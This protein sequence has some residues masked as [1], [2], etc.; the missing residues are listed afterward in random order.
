MQFAAAH[1]AP[2]DVGRLYNA[3]YSIMDNADNPAIG[4]LNNTHV[5]HLAF[6]LLSVGCRVSVAASDIGPKVLNIM[7]SA[8]E[9]R[10]ACSALRRVVELSF[11][12]SISLP[13]QGG[14]T[15]WLNR[16]LNQKA[17]KAGCLTQKIGKAGCL[18]QKLGKAGCPNQ[19]LG[20]AGRLNRKIGEVG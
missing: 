4:D 15:K 10:L 6:I 1:Q 17:G 14:T 5:L 8:I 9:T 18:N 19:R 2:G 13:W 20:K 12:Q 7:G 3:P 16:C 11:I